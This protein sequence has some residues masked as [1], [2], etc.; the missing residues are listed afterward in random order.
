MHG[1]ERALLGDF[2]KVEGDG[3]LEIVM[4]GDLSLIK[5]VAARMTLGRVTIHGDAGMHTGA[6]MHG[7]ELQSSAMQAIGRAPR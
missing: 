1:N 3:S 4:N 2:F 7:G 6:Y 5:D